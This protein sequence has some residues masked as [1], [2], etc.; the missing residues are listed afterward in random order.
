MR[1]KGIAV[2]VSSLL[3]LAGL[4][5]GSYY[6]IEAPTQASL[7]IIKYP[8]PILREN[9]EEVEV[10]DDKIK[11]L[12]D[13]MIVTMKK[14]GGVGLAAPQVGVAKRVIVVQTKD[15]AQGFINPEILERSDEEE[16]GLEK[17]LSIPGREV[18][19]KRAKTIVI[20]SLNRE[21]KEIIMEVEGYEARVFQHEIDHINGILIIDYER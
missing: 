16:I 15:G 12:I 11:G 13:D 20:K 5:L 1:K 10:V 18:E 9:C 8:A 6:L 21:G 14:K 19:V 2:L 3:I 7:Q 4:A 17:C